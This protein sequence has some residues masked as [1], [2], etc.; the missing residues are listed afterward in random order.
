MKGGGRERRWGSRVTRPDAELAQNVVCFLP[1]SYSGAPLW[2]N[3]LFIYFFLN[4][5]E[6][7]SAVNTFIFVFLNNW[8][9]E[10]TT[11]L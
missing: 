6:F 3:I 10:I 4:Q 9:G 1:Q 11:V 7:D 2:A 5:I 8:G